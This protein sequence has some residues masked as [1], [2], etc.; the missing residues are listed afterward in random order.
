MSTDP[1]TCANPS[2]RIALLIDADNISHG[3][4]DRIVA[5]ARKHGSADIRRAYGN[6]ASGLNSWKAKLQAFAIKPEQHFA[7]ACGKNATDLA[8]A[9]DAIELVHTQKLDG[10]CIVSSDADFTPLVMHLKDKGF[11]VHGIGGAKTPKALVAAYTTFK[12]LD[13]PP[14]PKASKVSA[15][16]QPK[17]TT[18]ALPKVAQVLPEPKPHT[19]DDPV[20]LEALTTVVKAASRPDGWAYLSTAGSLVKDKASV[21]PRKYGQKGFRALFEAVGWFDIM[22][23]KKVH[24]IAD[25]RN[26]ERAAR[27]TL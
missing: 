16:E 27:P 24:F 22:K 15:D 1:S 4:L 12:Y 21:E 13:G 11:D 17:F 18:K 23:V 19:I 26:K 9:I 8:L 10:F 5:E 25:R 7:Y 3:K 14:D 20:L 6:W 2:R